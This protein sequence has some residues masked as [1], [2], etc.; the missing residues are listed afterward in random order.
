MYLFLAVL[1]LRCFMGFSLALANGDYALVL[2][3]MLLIAVISPVVVVGM[4]ALVVVAHGLSRCSSQALEHRL[5]NCGT[6]AY[7]LHMWDPPRSGIKPVC[8]P[9]A[10]RFFMTEPPGKLISYL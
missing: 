1:G 8:P 4:Q 3:H 6:Q 2:V 9:L 5:S 10:G 7:F